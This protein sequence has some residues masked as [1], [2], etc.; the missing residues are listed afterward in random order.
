M[1]GKLFGRA[2]DLS[3]A[4]RFNVKINFSKRQFAW[5]SANIFAVL[6]FILWLERVASESKIFFSVCALEKSFRLIGGNCEDK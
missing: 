5:G 1:I 2:E 4:H 6:W 3:G